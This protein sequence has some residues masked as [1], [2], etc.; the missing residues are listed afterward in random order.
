MRWTIVLL[1]VTTAATAAEQA[2]P[3][4]ET[5]DARVAEGRGFAA[6]LGMGLKTALSGAIADDGPLGAIDVC[7]IEAPASAADVSRPGVRVGRTALRVR[8]PANAPDREARA[9]LE[10]FARRLA[11]GEPADTLED[12]RTTPRGSRYMKAIVTQP[13]CTTCHGVAVAPALKQA[14]LERYPA[15]QALGFEAGSLRGAF[16]VEW[17]DAAGK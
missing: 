16:I 9:V 12:L 7:R 14:T 3:Q 11:A 6:Q 5:V 10:E 17:T 13:M 8:N 1:L 4:R 2:A 15:D